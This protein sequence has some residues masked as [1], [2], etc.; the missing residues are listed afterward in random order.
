LFSLRPLTKGKS[1][2]LSALIGEM[3]KVSGTVEI[4]GKSGLVEQRPWLRNQTVKENILFGAKFDEERFNQ[5]IKVCQLQ[6]DLQ[7]WPEAENTMIG[8]KGIK[9]R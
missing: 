6:P 8:D 1:S 9:L 5:V 2:L 3:L 7:M 4:W